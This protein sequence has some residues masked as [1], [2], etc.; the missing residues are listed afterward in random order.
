MKKIRKNRYG[1]LARI[2]PEELKARIKWKHN[3]KYN[4][5][6][7][8]PVII[9]ETGTPGLIID[10][11]KYQRKD[12]IYLVETPTGAS[13]WFREREIQEMPDAED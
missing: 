11:V 12:V 2:I 4:F 1:P 7:D 13:A 8:Q 10:R 5:R 9:R 3:P 6:L